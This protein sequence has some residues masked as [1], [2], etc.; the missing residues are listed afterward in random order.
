MAQIEASMDFSAAADD[1]SWRAALVEKCAVQERIALLD[2][3]SLPELLFEMKEEVHGFNRTE[4]A[5]RAA[6]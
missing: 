4:R 1:E 6:G 3:L 2:S 5:V